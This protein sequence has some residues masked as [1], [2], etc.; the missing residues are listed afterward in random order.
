MQRTWGP[1][2]PAPSWWVPAGITI[3]PMGSFRRRCPVLRRVYQA[4]VGAG[5]D[6]KRYASP[7]YY[8]IYESRC[9]NPYPKD[10]ALGFVWEKGYRR[11]ATSPAR[12]RKGSRMNTKQLL[13]RKIF[14]NYGG[15]SWSLQGLGMLRLNLSRELRLHVWDARFA[16]PN[17]STIHDHPWDFESEIVVGELTNQTYGCYDTASRFMNSK[18]N[19]QTIICGPGGCAMGEP[20]KVFLDPDRPKTY[21]AGDIYKQKRDEI[22]DTTYL[23]GTVTLVTRTFYEDTEHAHVFWQGEKWISAE[24]RPATIGEVRAI[25][26]NALE[27]WFS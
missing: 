7:R 20:E 22:H 4:G 16:V 10:S 17:V 12:P 3:E 26:N 21:R 15:Y 13:V 23:D 5:K 24:P 11:G 18:Y 25:V 2:G 14:E 19:K 9:T 8:W 6:S 27:R 1:Y